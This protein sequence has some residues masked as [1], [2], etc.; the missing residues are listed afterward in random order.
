MTNYEKYDYMLHSKFNDAICF[1]R[2]NIP[3]LKEK[4]LESADNC[5][6]FCKCENCRVEVLKWLTE[7]A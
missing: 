3:E 2:H 1:A 6:D 7:E 4:C 5:D